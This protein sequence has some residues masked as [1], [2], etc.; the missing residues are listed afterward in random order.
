MKLLELYKELSNNTTVFTN[1]KE[2]VA[3]RRKEEDDDRKFCY[4]L[5]NVLGCRSYNEFLD[6]SLIA[7]KINSLFKSMKGIPNVCWFGNNKNKG[8]IKKLIEDLLYDDRHDLYQNMIYALDEIYKQIKEK[9]TKDFFW[10]SIVDILIDCI[11][12]EGTEDVSANF[13]IKEV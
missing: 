11:N 7:I 4:Y 12:T 3:I 2:M 1:F 6:Y 8:L 5:L 13:V 10:G 9:E